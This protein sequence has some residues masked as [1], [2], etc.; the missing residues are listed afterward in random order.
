MGTESD[1]YLLTVGKVTKDTDGAA[2]FQFLGY[3]TEFGVSGTPASIA[4]TRDPIHTLK[5]A[6]EDDDGILEELHNSKSERYRLT[7]FCPP[8]A[9]KKYRVLQRRTPV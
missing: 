2:A 1:S 7:I 6:S 5:I 8:N 4:L 9:P 3:G